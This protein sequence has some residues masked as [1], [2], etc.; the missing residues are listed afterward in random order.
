M[1]NLKKYFITGL[2]II[3]PVFLSI[4]VLVYIFL[5][6][7]KILGRFFSAKF[8]WYV[9]GPGF[10]VFLSLVV[11]V[12]FLANRFLGHKIF[13]TLE[14]WFSELPLINKIY[15]TV[16]QIVGF[17]SAQKEFGFKKVVLVEYPSKGLWSMGFLTNEQFVQINRSVGK[18]M[19]SVYIATVPGPLTGN[20]IFV[21][22][23]DVRQVDIS[24]GD[25][26]KIIISG[27]VVGL[28]NMKR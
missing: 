12:G 25:A 1:K 18:D 17:I 23:E 3:V 15:P 7:D 24:I 5:F 4:Y 22:K 28:A 6:T 19:V 27:G 26:L 13:I 8:G 2:A 20:L 14:K 9:P 21:P 16:K 10:I 11:F